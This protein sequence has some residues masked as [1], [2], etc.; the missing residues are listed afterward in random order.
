MATIISDRIYTPD[1]LLRMPDGK[2]FELVDGQL[3][4]QEMGILEGRVAVLIGGMISAFIESNQLGSAFGSELG[5]RC[6]PWEPNKIRKPDASFIAAD[7]L[8]AEMFTAGFAEIAPDLAIEVVSPNDPYREVETKVDEYLRAGVRL[9]WVLNPERQLV[10]VHR[11][12]G[13]VSEVARGGM[14]SGEDVLPGF[15]TPVAPLF[16]L[17]PGLAASSAS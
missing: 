13:T 3:V 6:F 5:Y 7:R 4:E 11:L 10:R 8:T 16:E 15:S 1:D 17:P 14:L 12:D 2:R 9:I